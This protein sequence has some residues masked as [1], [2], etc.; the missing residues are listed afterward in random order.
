MR[1]V[2]LP[3]VLRPPSDSHMLAGQLRREALGQSTK[4]LDLCSGSGILAIVAARGGA[5]HV[6]AVDISARAVVNTWLNA[7]LN[8]VSVEIVRG[9]LFAAVEGRKFD[10]IVSNPPYLVSASEELPTRGSLQALDAGPT[11]RILIDRICT[12]VDAHLAPGGVLLLVHSSLCDDRRTV[13]LLEAGG[14]EV[15]IPLRHNGRLGKRMRA[16]APML[17]ARGLLGNGEVEDIVV[18]RATRPAAA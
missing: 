14:Y 15:A 3:G 1:L 6:T 13:D 11:G 17:R 10:V 9:D 2:I 4:V 12:E 16:R 8:G 18:I 5:G 7:K